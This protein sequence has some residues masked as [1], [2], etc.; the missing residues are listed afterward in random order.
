M[1]VKI[2]KEDDSRLE[3]ELKDEDHTIGNLLRTTLLLDKHVKQAGY[4]IIH[5]LTGGI[6]IV[7]YTDGEEKPRE[8]IIKALAKIEEDA[9]ELQGKLSD[10][11]K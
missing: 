1:S 5:P 6:R 4:Q 11:L 2:V 9:K 3:L 10:L 8:A 7:V